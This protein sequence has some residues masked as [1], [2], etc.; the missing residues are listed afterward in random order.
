MTNTSHL[1]AIMTSRQKTEMYA[2]AEKLN[3]QHLI[4]WCLI[5]TDRVS[6]ESNKKARFRK[7]EELKIIQK[8]L[9]ERLS[10]NGE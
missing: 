6:D 9:A 2:E 7:L 3:N 5:Y 10:G 1:K 8:V 4:T